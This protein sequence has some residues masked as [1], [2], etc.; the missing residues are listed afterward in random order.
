MN[1]TS[2]FTRAD[3]ESALAHVNANGFGESVDED[4]IIE[5]AAYAHLAAMPAGTGDEPARYHVRDAEI[6][7]FNRD[8]D[9]DDASDMYVMEVLGAS[10]LIRRAYR[11]EDGDYLRIAIETDHQ[12]EFAVIVNNDE[13]YYGEDKDGGL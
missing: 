4:A 1:G 9:T 12:G 2:T 5:M 13:N 11:G 10:V 7:V 8:W 6:R 3:L